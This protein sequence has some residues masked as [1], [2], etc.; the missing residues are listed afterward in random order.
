MTGRLVVRRIPDLNPGTK[1]GQD[2][3]V[4]TWRFH[5]LFT[6]TDPDHDHDHTVATDKIHRG[7]AII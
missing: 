2:T 3:L 1:H 6:T 5:A 4:D 7:H